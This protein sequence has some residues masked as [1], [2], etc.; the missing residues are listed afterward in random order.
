MG[1]RRQARE[2]A[3]KVLF[4]MDRG[5]QPL[6][7]VCAYTFENAAASPETLA[8]ARRLAEGV[9]AEREDIDE[10][11]AGRTHHWRLDRLSAVDR[12]VLRLG[13]YEMPRCPEVPR[14]VVINEAIEI[15]KK[16]CAE[17]S[18]RFVNGVLDGL[19]GGHPAP[20]KKK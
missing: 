8:Y 1:R 10:R 18:G 16:Y 3:L 19:P 7:R 5:V 2:L 17:E 12:N 14:D 15:A 20:G 13:A 4:Q 6:A 11:L 9:T